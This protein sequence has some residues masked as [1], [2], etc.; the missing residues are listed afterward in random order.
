[1]KINNT[2]V[3]YKLD[4]KTPLVDPDNQQEKLTVWKTLGQILVA[5]DTQENR[6]KYFVLWTK[7]YS[8]DEIEIDDSD[9]EMIKNACNKTVRYNSLVAWQLL[10]IL[11]W[12]QDSKELSGW[13]K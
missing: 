6:L 9:Y 1:M 13:V 8:S 7:F 10:K 4:G 5:H 3:L 2:A 11:I 12:I